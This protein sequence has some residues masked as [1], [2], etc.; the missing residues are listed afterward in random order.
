MGSGPARAPLPRSM[1]SASRVPIAL[2]RLGV[3]IGPLRLLRTQGRITGRPAETPLALTR[4]DGHDWL[5]SPFG[6]TGWVRNYRANAVAEF[7]RGR[8]RRPVSL[9]EVD[10]ERRT[11]VL[12]R[13][14]SRYRLVPF[15]RTAFTARPSDALDAFETE[16]HLHPVFQLSYPEQ[17]LAFLRA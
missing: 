16:A 13:Y 12:R 6:E 5:V 11:S 4:L 10:D 7:V 17:P 2:L 8:T 15:V 3:P 1:L 14:R 9:V